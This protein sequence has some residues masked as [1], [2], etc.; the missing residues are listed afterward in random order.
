MDNFLALG[1]GWGQKKTAPKWE[2]LLLVLNRRLR[3]LAAVLV[4]VAEL[5]HPTSGVHQF[6]LTGVEGVAYG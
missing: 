2:Q 6:H 5:V 4:A 1:W 3:L